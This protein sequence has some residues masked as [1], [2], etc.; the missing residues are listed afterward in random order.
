MLDLSLAKHFAWLLR[1][2][3]RQ[4]LRSADKPTE[5]FAQWWLVNGR[6]EY[7]YWGELNTAQM[8]WLQESAGKGT[9]EGVELSIPK[10]LRLVLSWRPDVI[11]KFTVNDGADSVSLMAWFYLLGM[12]EHRLFD[13]M[14]LEMIGDLDR[15][16]LNNASAPG[17][18]TPAVTVLMALAWRL[19]GPDLQQ[20]MN[21]S[22]SAARNRYLAWFFTA[23]LSIFKCHDLIANRW[24]SWLLQP[25]PVGNGLGELPRFALLEYSSLPAK[26][27]P[28]ITT[29]A[30]VELLRTWAASPA[31]IGV[32]KGGDAQS[33]LVQGKWA[34]LKQ[35]TQIPRA[36]ASPK[37]AVNL[38]TD[39]SG[40]LPVTAKKPFGVN[41]FGFAYGELGI[42]ED[43]R[44]AVAC[45]E[46]A[47][48]EYRVINIEPGTE[49][50]QNDKAVQE[51]VEQGVASAA[52]AINVFILPGFDI[53][54]RVFLKMGSEVFKDHY[55]I[56]WCPWELG[57]WPAAWSRAF[58][59][60]DEVWAGS[61]FSHEMYSR[62]TQKPAIAMPL[63]TQLL[64]LQ[65]KTRKHFGLPANEFLF[66][67]VFDFN[68]HL[69]RK[70]PTAV[71]EGFATAFPKGK[72]VSKDGSQA[73]SKVGLVLKVMNAKASD[74]AW[75][76]FEKSCKSDKRIHLINQ[77]MDRGEVLALIN[78]CDAY[79]S[80]HRAEG[81][82]R[83]LTE[84]MLLGKPVVATNYSGNAFYMN[85]EV[86]FP[87]DYELVP[88]KR[89]DYYFVEDED[90]AVWANP[91]I[92]HLASQ[93]QA[94]IVA[95]K[96]PQFKA[97]LLAYAQQTFAPRRT[98][99]LMQ[100]RLEFIKTLLIERGL[101]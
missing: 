21:L 64:G 56:G 2:D 35:P 72:A 29:A 36:S 73:G 28:D 81:F 47:G 75:Q 43:L 66:L 20:A 9:F 10:M 78:V 50:R 76:K 87:V 85:P 5:R 12:Q 32:G 34:W 23:G 93:M 86:T 61:Q 45:C 1:P 4:D 70:N 17:D 27:R 18:E 25:I 39:S 94:A 67:Y 68:S 100:A 7:P 38:L 55:N 48:V 16:I 92:A 24:R 58:E 71:L 42:G 37:P 77:T 44:M 97:N 65:K 90:G 14:S 88:V 63:A 99:Q 91:S 80:P 11:Q 62:S 15:P 3:V 52:F 69:E 46:A 82:G 51:Q 89:G 101:V 30:G 41:L 19:L 13:A 84:A 60:I 96:D 57:L 98:G 83:T 26:K 54:S 59:L 40:V 22:D 6:S 49:I 95:A 79:V 53:A 31:A 74:P 33:R 8:A